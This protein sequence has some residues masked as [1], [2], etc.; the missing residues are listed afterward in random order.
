MAYLLALAGGAGSG[1]STL[2]AALGEELPGTM[3]VHLDAHVHRDTTAAPCVPVIGGVG[4]TVDFSD[5]GSV[6]RE[7]TE[8]AVDAALATAPHLV[9]VEGTFALTLPYI[10]DRARWTAYLSVPAD[11]RLARKTVRKLSAGQNPLPG[12][13]GYLLRARAAHDHHVEPMEQAAQLVLDGTA[14]VPDLVRGLRNFLAPQSSGPH[15]PAARP[16]G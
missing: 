12:L 6:N 7:E 9:I 2:A 1:K 13:Q 11:I 16:F 5:P 15:Q 10:R 14:P 3:V 8:A 4:L